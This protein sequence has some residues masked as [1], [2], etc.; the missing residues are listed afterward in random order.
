MAVTRR[1]LGRI[2]TVAAVSGTAVAQGPQ[3]PV[4]EKAVPAD[5]QLEAARQRLRASALSIA[6][7]PLGRDVEPAFRFQA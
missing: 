3:A 7:V 5:P 1:E 6:Q 2:L 4:A